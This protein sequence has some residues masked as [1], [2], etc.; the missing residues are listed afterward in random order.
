MCPVRSVTHVS[1]RAKGLQRCNPF[2]FD[3]LVQ[4]LKGFQCAWCFTVGTA[5][6]TLAASFIGF[7]LANEFLA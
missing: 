2:F 4:G 7:F 3:L 5:V 1:G 6:P